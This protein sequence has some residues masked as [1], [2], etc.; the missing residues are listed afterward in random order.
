M[1]R[2]TQESNTSSESRAR[3]GL[4]ELR[5]AARFG[6]R[7]LAAALIIAETCPATCLS[8]LTPVL[9]HCA[10]RPSTLLQPCADSR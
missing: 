4:S 9:T 5:A 2:R 6:Y 3:D 8:G 10:A 1:R 7:P